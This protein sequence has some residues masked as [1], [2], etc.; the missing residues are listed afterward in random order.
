MTVSEAGIA[1]VLATYNGAKSLPL[2]LEAYMHCAPPDCPWHIIVVDNA[3]TDDTQAVLQSFADRLP[4][5]ILSEPGRGKN[6]AL[7]RALL[8]D[9]RKGN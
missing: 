2:V 7:N 9:A 6:R 4:L 1:I 5:R 3:S 8:D